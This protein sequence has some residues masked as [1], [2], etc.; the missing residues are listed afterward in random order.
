MTDCRVPTARRCQGCGATLAEPEAESTVVTCRFCGLAHDVAS[1]AFQA[2]GP[3]VVQ[4]GGASAGRAGRRLGLILAIIGV[5]VAVVTLVPMWL[6]YRIG[7]DVV[8][9]TTARLPSRVDRPVLAPADLAVVPMGQGWKRID[10]P[11]PPGGFDTFDP[12][13]GIAW[14][15]TIGH[16]WAADAVLTRVDVGR[17]AATGAIDLSGE[18][19]S[20][21]RLTSAGRQ[22]QRKNDI[23]T[24]TRSEIG[25]ELLLQ[26]KGGS[27]QALVTEGREAAPPAAPVSL[28]LE[29]I[30]G[31]ARKGQGFVERP[32]YTGYMIHLPREGWVWYFSTPS[33]DGLPRVRARDGRAYPYR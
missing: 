11:P 31:G 1:P 2:Q 9:R 27:V 16:A 7:S 33:G 5:L 25:T 24:G 14:A 12:V 29:Q 8:E 22:V 28:G 17:V 18:H 15:T 26:L 6:A 21:Y 30:L 3:V 23:D 4:I 32:F 19:P 10:V 20:G 13:A